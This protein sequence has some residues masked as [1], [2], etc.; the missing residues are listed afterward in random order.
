MVISL[1]FSREEESYKAKLINVVWNALSSWK[2]KSLQFMS[3][4]EMLKLSYPWHIMM[5]ENSMLLLGD[6][7]SMFVDNAAAQ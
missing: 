4:F 6:F 5:G 2:Y 7:K 1:S 3:I